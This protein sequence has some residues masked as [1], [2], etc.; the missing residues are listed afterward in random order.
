MAKMFLDQQIDYTSFILGLSSAAL[1]YLGVE[2][3][4]ARNEKPLKINLELAKQNIDILVLIE[5]KT[6]GNL[7][8]DEARLTSQI[9]YDLR[10]KF[11]E[12]VKKSFAADS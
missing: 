10:I 2:D 11:S 7:S 4:Q 6:K 8:Q 5:E 12:A 9:L 1:S 3:P